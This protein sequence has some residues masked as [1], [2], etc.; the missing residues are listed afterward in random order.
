MQIC[1][2]QNA[3]SFGINIVKIADQK[4]LDKLPGDVV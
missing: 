3:Q 4:S 1:T 2:I